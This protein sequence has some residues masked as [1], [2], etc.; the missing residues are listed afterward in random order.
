MTIKNHHF[1]FICEIDLTY[2]DHQ[3]I[4]TGGEQDVHT[5]VKCH[6][7]DDLISR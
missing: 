1:V 3:W 7:S 2:K 5:V 4:L 6:P